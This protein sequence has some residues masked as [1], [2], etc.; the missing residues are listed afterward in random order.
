MFVQ[1]HG[2]EYPV[3]LGKLTGKHVG[4]IGSCLWLWSSGAIADAIVLVWCNDDDKTCR[5]R[6]SLSQES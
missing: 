2:G 5:N 6:I 1:I 3:W 4:T